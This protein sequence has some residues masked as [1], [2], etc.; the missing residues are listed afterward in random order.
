MEMQL[1]FTMTR[2]F[3]HAAKISKPMASG[4]VNEDM[5][6]RMEKRPQVCGCSPADPAYPIRAI[7]VA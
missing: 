4:H 7:R 3:L 6:M 1:A 2:F 5:Q